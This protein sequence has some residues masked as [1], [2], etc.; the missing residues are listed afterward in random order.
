MIFFF[1]HN[2][3]QASTPSFLDEDLDFESLNSDEELEEEDRTDISHESTS[4]QQE[5][6]SQTSLVSSME[7]KHK[8]MAEYVNELSDESDFQGL[9]A[10]DGIN[11]QEEGYT[12]S[13]GA[14]VQEGYDPGYEEEEE[15]EDRDT[16][17]GPG[18]LLASNY[19]GNE[20]CDGDKED[21]I[22]AKGQHPAPE[23]TKT[24]QVR[25]EEQ[26][27]RWGD[28]EASYFERVPEHDSRLRIKGDFMGD[29]EQESEEEEQQAHWSDS[30]SKA[31]ENVLSQSFE[32]EAANP[33]WDGP[34][35]ASLVQ[36]P[37][38]LIAVVESEE[39]V[40]KMKDF[41][42]EEHQEAGESFAEYPS[43]FS[44]IEYVGDGGEITEGNHQSTEERDASQEGAAGWMERGQDSDE[45]RQECLYSIDLQVAAESFSSQDETDKGKTDIAEGVSGDMALMGLETEESRSFSS[46]DDEA[47][48]DRSD[49]ELYENLCPQELE[50][51]KQQEELHSGYNPT[52]SNISWSPDEPFDSFLSDELLTTDQRDKDKGETFS[53]GTHKEGISTY[54][55]TQR[56][57]TR[58]P[59]NQGSL[60]D[61]FFF[62]PQLEASELSMLGPL[63]DDDYEEER[64]WEQEQER[65][66][67]FNDFY[68]D[69]GELNGQVSK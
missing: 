42:G 41:S 23:G 29:E 55:M 13:A 66:K 57:D 26:G 24:P 18:G 67:A 3:L 17:E 12:S 31:E 50:N 36:D 35:K 60:D 59:S 46:T 64:N 16:Q 48:V 65:I 15:E 21:R 45:V 19:H 7:S 9:G 14:S 61:S 63:G 38:D 51:I 22:F 52:D 69:M 11:T 40:L 56:G 20:F 43:D 68:D 47:P 4:L 30:E 5:A 1:L 58:S 37:Q 49:E 53:I 39:Y 10:M 28:E 8:Y 25:N 2:L 6:A 44:S 27:E 33:A 32:Q 54:S 34:S 62:N